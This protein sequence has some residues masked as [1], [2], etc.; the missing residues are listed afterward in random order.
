MNDYM[1]LLCTLEPFDGLLNGR[2]LC[3]KGSLL[4]SEVAGALGDD[5]ALSLIVLRDHP[6]KSSGFS[7]RAIRP[8]VTYPVS[9]PRL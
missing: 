9:V 6:P 7:V 8:G 4:A 2:H 5:W 3:V 1:A